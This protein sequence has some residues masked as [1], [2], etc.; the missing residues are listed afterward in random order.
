MSEALTMQ[1]V[2]GAMAKLDRSR[3]N[4]LAFSSAP[5]LTVSPYLPTVQRPRKL[6]RWERVRVWFEDLVDGAG[7]TREAF[8]WRRVLRTEPVPAPYAYLF[9]SR[10]LVHSAHAA[11]VRTVYA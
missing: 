2:L 1:D 5:L 4:P 6:S 7:L 9:D 8:P 3:F 10:L 11:L